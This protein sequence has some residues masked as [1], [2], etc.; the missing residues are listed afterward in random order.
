MI[1]VVGVTVVQTQSRL[2]LAHRLQ[3]DNKTATVLR[4]LTFFPIV[5]GVTVVGI[6]WLLLFDPVW[7]PA[8]AALLG[9]LGATRRSSAQ[10]PWRCPW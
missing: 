10:T 7:S 6:V 4:V 3:A 8:Q 2:L 9:C 5:L 1:F